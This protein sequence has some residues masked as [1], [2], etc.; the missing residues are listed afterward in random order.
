MST[1]ETSTDRSAPDA[2][3]GALVHDLSVQIPELV[4]SELRLA[5]AELA[6]KGKAA[7]IGAGL[8]GVAGLLAQDRF[9][10]TAASEV[11]AIVALAQSHEDLEKRLSRVV[12]GASTSGAPITAGDVGAAGAMTALLRDALLP[13]LVQTAEGGPA[14][15][16][17]G[18]FGNIA[19]GCS[20]ILATRLGL[21]AA[22]YTITEA[23][24]GF[25][26][27]GEKFLDI[28][29]RSAGLSPAA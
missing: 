27:G 4:R 9:D 10:I 28:K 25:D 13:N 2:P 16:H 19:H 7:G 26:L 23:G 1:S 24:F 17:A 18:P 20:S 29:C 22:D 11:M 6:Q 5:Q 14:L 3:L 21:A 12:V 15:V 8:F